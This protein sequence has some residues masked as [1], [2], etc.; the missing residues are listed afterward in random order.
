M[1][2]SLTLGRRVGEV[3]DVAGEPAALDGVLQRLSDRRVNVTDR[4]RRETDAVTF[5]LP[6]HP[7]VEAVEVFGLKVT[8]PDG[9]ER[10]DEVSVHARR[11]VGK[12]RGLDA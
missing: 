3:R 5:P 10:R 7:S 11:V 12:G 2:T 4:L 9:P 8:E 1:R 6:L